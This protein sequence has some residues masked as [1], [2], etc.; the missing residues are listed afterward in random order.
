MIYLF[1]SLLIDW[2]HIYLLTGLEL[3]FSCISTNLF[4]WR[5]HGASA[6]VFQK[7]KDDNHESVEF[8]AASA[9]KLQIGAKHSKC[10]NLWKASWL[11]HGSRISNYFWS[12]RGECRPYIDKWSVWE[13]MQIW[14][15]LISINWIS[16]T[17]EMR[18]SVSKLVMQPSFRAVGQTHA[19]WQTFEKLEMIRD[20]CMAVRSSQFC[21]TVKFASLLQY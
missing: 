3:A 11:H 14:R 5:L 8:C 18:K 13:L 20:K 4:V 1:I 2:F 16:S 10:V 21:P 19:E 17:K 15:L 6:A 12:E 7:I 9:N